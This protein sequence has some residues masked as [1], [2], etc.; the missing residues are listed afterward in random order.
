MKTILTLITTLL[1]N[2]VAYSQD[3]AHPNS[4][5]T[6]IGGHHDGKMPAQDIVKAGKID[7]S[8]TTSHIS[9]FNMSFL[10][11]GNLVTLTG[12]SNEL[13]KEM[14]DAISTLKPGE[15]LFFE[16]VEASDKAGHTHK[17]TGVA[18]VLE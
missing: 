17:I 12:H 9:K 11:E 15:K 14:K 7:V 18:L 10:K 3:N 8:D 16:G 5:T 4:V 2:F 6:S 13:T 1:V